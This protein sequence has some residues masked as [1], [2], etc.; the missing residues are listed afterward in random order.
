MKHHRLPGWPGKSNAATDAGAA[1]G[2]IAALTYSDSTGFHDIDMSLHGDAPAIDPAWIHTVRKARIAVAAVPW[3]DDVQQ[4]ANTFLDAAGTLAETLDE[5]HVQS[6][7]TPARATH[8]AQHALSNAGWSHLA[9]AAGIQ[10]GGNSTHEP[11]R[12]D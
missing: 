7:L 6:A 8:A 12:P 11:R 1:G 3:P 4:A 9:H 5:G 2:M 10:V